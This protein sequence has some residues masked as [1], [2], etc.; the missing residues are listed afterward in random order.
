VCGAKL[1]PGF[2]HCNDCV[3]KDREMQRA[4]ALSPAKNQN[5]LP[6]TTGVQIPG[7]ASNQTRRKESMKISEYIKEKDFDF[8]LPQGDTIIELDTTEIEETT[9]KTQD[10]KEKPTWKITIPNG[11]SYNI[12][13]SVLAAIKTIAEKGGKKVRVTRTGTQLST[14]YTT[15]EVK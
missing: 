5:S 3:R 15:V 14:R 7:S 12:P 8:G 1:E 13:K 4:G 10:G 11:E 2:I 6:E 9:F